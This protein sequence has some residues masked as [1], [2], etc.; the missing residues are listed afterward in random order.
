MEPII[1]K[2]LLI[3]EIIPSDI[4]V[5][6]SVYSKIYLSFSLF[7]STNQI[8]LEKEL[9]LKK[10]YLI[11]LQMIILDLHK[12][13]SFLKKHLKEFIKITIFLQKHLCL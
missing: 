1:T 9:F 11:L 12:I 7:Y 4:N 8:D 6:L 5:L 2:N 3:R 10:I 13:E